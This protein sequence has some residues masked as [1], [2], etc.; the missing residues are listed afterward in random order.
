MIQLVR[1]SVQA[2]SEV[3][4]KIDS[5]SQAWLLTVLPPIGLME[6]MKAMARKSP[7]KYVQISYL[8]YH[9]TDSSDP[10]L[11]A[12]KRSDDPDIRSAADV[13]EAAIERAQ[14]ASGQ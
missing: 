14:A 10:M 5:I 4:A 1:E 12:A 2:L 3:F 6:P 9:V 8:L 11:D 7:D 13:V